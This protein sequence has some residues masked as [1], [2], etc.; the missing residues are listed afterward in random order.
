MTKHD[1]W[2]HT[3][4]ALHAHVLGFQHPVTGKDLRFISPMP[5][6][7][8][9]FI[10]LQRRAEREAAAEAAGENLPAE[11]QP[12]EVKKKPRDLPVKQKER[13]ARPKSPNKR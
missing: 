4:L 1:D 7:F 9:I 2:P 13:L 10:R 6:S 8:Q 12:V 11:E 5:R 3:R